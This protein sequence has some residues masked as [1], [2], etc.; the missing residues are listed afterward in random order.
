MNLLSV[1]HIDSNK[2]S[3]DDY[4]NL[5][6]RTIYEPHLRSHIEV[7]RMENILS[8]IISYGMLSK[9]GISDFLMRVLSCTLFTEL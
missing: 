7:V 8:K 6:L 3:P 1:E 5:L 2:Y 4:A 9:I